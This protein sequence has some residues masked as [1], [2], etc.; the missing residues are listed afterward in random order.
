MIH[1]G[2]TKQVG[3]HILRNWTKMAIGKIRKTGIKYH[4]A[5]TL[6]RWSTYAG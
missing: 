5:S 3:P 1:D 6:K 4:P 2:K